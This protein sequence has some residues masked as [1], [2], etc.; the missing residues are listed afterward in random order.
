M[1][2][3]MDIPSSTI[4]IRNEGRLNQ[5]TRLMLSCVLKCTVLKKKR[6]EE[7]SHV[8]IS[9]RLS[10]KGPRLIYSEIAVRV[11]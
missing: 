4:Q 3:L 11:Q 2:L 7:S 8:V 5:K 6:W 9:V 10:G 1:F